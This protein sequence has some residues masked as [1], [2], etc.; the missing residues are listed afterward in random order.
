M[1]ICLLPTDLHGSLL[2]SEFLLSVPGHGFGVGGE[3][4]R[5][6]EVSWHGTLLG[7]G[8]QGLLQL[9]RNVNVLWPTY[10]VSNGDLVPTEK[11]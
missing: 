10:C 5:K 11:A 4:G 6:N 3:T 1:C 8:N 2:F 7:L 9:Q